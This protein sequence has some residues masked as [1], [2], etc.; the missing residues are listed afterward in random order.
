[1]HR[2]SR[3]W[4]RRVTAP[5]WPSSL[6]RVERG[7]HRSLGF[8]LGGTLKRLGYKRGEWRDVSYWQRFNGPDDD[9]PPSPIKP[10]REVAGVEPFGRS[11]RSPR[12]S[13]C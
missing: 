13:S 3:S 10:V 1:V 8:T 2:C 5:S 9:S 11:D 4:T 12:A 6:F 7:L